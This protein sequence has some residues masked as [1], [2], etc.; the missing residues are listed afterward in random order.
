[1]PA[2][3]EVQA[4][5]RTDQIRQRHPVPESSGQR[6]GVTV[7]QAGTRHAVL[8][9]ADEHL[10]QRAIYP[11]VGGQAEMLPA[12]DHRGGVPA[13]ASGHGCGQGRLDRHDSPGIKNYILKNSPQLLQLKFSLAGPRPGVSQAQTVGANHRTFGINQ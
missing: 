11:L 5:S 6:G 1:V 3:R 13:P 8:A 12:D 10:A 2:G 7:Q 4:E 9:P